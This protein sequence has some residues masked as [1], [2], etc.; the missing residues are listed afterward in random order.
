MRVH[1]CLH[2]CE[3]AGRVDTPPQE[4]SD[5]GDGSDTEKGLE[6]E[7]E[8]LAKQAR[9]DPLEP[10]GECKLRFVFWYAQQ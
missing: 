1:Q 6:E 9:P 7:I 4:L 3:G 5:A 2:V 8:P 10:L